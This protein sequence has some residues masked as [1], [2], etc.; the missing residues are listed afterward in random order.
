[1]LACQCGMQLQVSTAE[2]YYIKQT[3]FICLSYNSPEAFDT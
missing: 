2:E 3:Y 1:M